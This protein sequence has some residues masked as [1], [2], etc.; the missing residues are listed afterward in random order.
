MDMAI[1]SLYSGSTGNATFIGTAEGAVLVDAGG[2]AKKLVT[3]LAHVDASPGDIRGILVTHEHIDHINA[4]GPL[5]R[6]HHLPVY[7]TAGTWAAMEASGKLGVMPLG[8]KVILQS[9]TDFFLAGMRITAHPTSH[10]A[11]E[12]VCYTFSRNG[13]HMAI[14]T[15]TGYMPAALA[16]RLC[17]CELIV[18][19]SNHD[20]EMLRSGPYPYPLKQRVLGPE[21]HLSNDVAAR[22][23]ADSAKQGTRDI[24]LAHLS[25]ENNTPQAAL[26]TVGRRLE[27]AGYTG[28][29]T[30]APRDTVSEA[31]RLERAICRK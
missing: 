22:F 2:T 24:I 19:E 25:K 20:V 27:A 18:L 30:V 4:I 13:H 7:A 11:A 29:L 12:P 31:H 3:A 16:D 17:G 5:C 6:K 1:C 8:C 23:A 9:S 28:G 26:N 15:D 14:A 21:G 10:D